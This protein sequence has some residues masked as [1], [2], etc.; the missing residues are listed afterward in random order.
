MSARPSNPIAS[1][2]CPLRPAVWVSALRSSAAA[3][4][5]RRD[6]FP[7]TCSDQWP[8]R[9]TMPGRTRVTRPKRYPD[10]AAR[11][12]A[13]VVGRQDVDAHVVDATSL[14]PAQEVL[15]VVGA[16]PVPLARVH[17]PGEACP[18]AVAVHDHAD[19]ARRH[20]LPAG[21]HGRHAVILS[22]LIRRWRSRRSSRRPR[23]SAGSH[24]A[25]CPQPTTVGLAGPAAAVRTSWRMSSGSCFAVVVG[26][27]G[28]GRR[29]ETRPDLG[30]VH[31]GD[32]SCARPSAQ[33]RC[34]AV[35]RRFIREATL[36]G[37]VF[38]R[39]WP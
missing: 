2:T 37:R 28:L 33:E 3:S 24:P 12:L 26:E 38:R 11:S 25:G 13:D 17:E 18:P 22:V 7:L 30:H 32:G 34:H 9:S 4:S 29:V 8:L 36:R 20:C 27:P 23:R 14:A 31:A 35:G 15:D 5:G 10:L 16:P 19:V 1:V 21:V 39:A 6:R